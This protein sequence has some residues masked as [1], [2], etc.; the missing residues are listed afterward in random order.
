MKAV[1]QAGRVQVPISNPDKVFYPKTG[2]TKG[3]VIDYYI[4]I[5]PVLLPHLRDR[6]VSMRRFPDGVEGISFFEKNCPSHRPEWVDTAPVPKKSGGEVNYCLLNDLPSL[7]WAANLADLEIH[8]F[9]HRARAIQRPTALVFDLDPG[10]PADLRQCCRVAGLVREVLGE[11]G[12][13]AFAKTSGSRGLHLAV[14]LNTAVTYERTGAFARAMAQLLEFR[15][16]DLVVSRMAK[17]LRKGKVFIDW[18][19][20]DDSKTTACV[21]SLRAREVPSV[22][23]PVTWDEVESISRTR[24]PPSFEPEEVLRRVERGG[25]LFA[26]VLTMKQ[27]LPRELPG[28]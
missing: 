11:A 26:G 25:D 8:T 18:S 7:I 16:P 3:E 23:T 12:L 27:K 21:Y 10:E 2:F 6:P 28:D 14:P 1:L 9:Q 4:R 5:S 24:K 19:Q 15:H 20:N 13:T 22:S 17:N